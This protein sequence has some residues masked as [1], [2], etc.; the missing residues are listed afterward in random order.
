MGYYLLDVPVDD[1][2][3]GVL[4]SCPCL[5]RKRERHTVE[6]QFRISNLALFQN[7][8]FE[9]FDPQVPGV[10]RAYARAREFAEHPKGWL[11]MFGNYGCGKTHLAAAIANRVFSKR[12]YGV[13]LSSVPDLL[14]NIRRTFGTEAE[15]D[16]NDR[17]EIIREVPLLILDD[18]GTEYITPWAKEKLYQIVDHRYNAQ[19]PTVVTSNQQPSTIEPRIFSRLSDRALSGEMLLIDARDYRQVPESQRQIWRRSVP[20]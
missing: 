3:F 12:G 11:V 17:F 10:W 4:M 20:S 18:L 13:I 7:K 6:E 5:L 16:Y 19:L 15:S 1:P 8:T 14:D 9:S 2:N